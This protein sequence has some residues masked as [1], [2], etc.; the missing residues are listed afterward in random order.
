LRAF[1]E[2]DTVSDIKYRLALCQIETL[3]EKTDTMDKAER[4]V[5]EAAESGADV[6]VLPEMFACPYARGY[7]EEFAESADGESVRR[8][9]YW[10]REYGV[11]LIGGSIPERDG[12]RLY[13]T[14]FVFD[15]QGRVIARHRKAH[16]FDVDIPG[17]VTFKES[18]FFSPGDDIC[19]FDTEFGRMGVA[20]CFDMRF[21]ELIRAMAERGA[22]TIIVPA[23]FNTT[24]GPAHWELTIRARA[25]DNELFFAACSAARSPDFKY[26]CW[27]HS[28][29]AGPFGN[30]LAACD[31]TEQTVLCDIDLSEVDRVRRQ[32]PTFL[33]LREDMYPV[34][35]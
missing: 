1:K 27:G 32:L 26:Q 12:G 18:D 30:V 7:F 31:E 24:T 13:N 14:C 16:M 19:V 17:G 22:E 8:M 2:G 29:A 25:I 35:K 34:A 9:A 21:P 11:Y 5:R 15:R 6:A 4:M 23:Q 3:P 20:I 28:T 10:A 33:R